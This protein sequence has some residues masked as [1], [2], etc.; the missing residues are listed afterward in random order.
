MKDELIGYLAL[1]ATIAFIF[2][3]LAQLRLWAVARHVERIAEAL[4]GISLRHQAREMNGVR[5]YLE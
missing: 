1:A 3:M 2:G 5:D 4:E